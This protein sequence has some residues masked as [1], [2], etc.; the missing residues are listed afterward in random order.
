MSKKQS[1]VRLAFF[2]ETN[3]II[4]I[5]KT[6]R[7][8]IYLIIWGVD[9]MGTDGR[10]GVVGHQ[11]AACYTHQQYAA[12]KEDPGD[13]LVGVHSILLACLALQSGDLLN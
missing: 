6:S 8:S 10:Y 7:L 11:D 4:I 2:S 13:S 5:S 12:N 9:L 3:D 1:D